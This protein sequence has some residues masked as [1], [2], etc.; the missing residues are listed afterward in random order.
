MFK[1]CDFEKETGSEKTKTRT[2]M[3]KCHR[4]PKGSK[5][6]ESFTDAA[7]RPLSEGTH[8]SS[9]LPPCTNCLGWLGAINRLI[10]L[11]DYCRPFRPGPCLATSRAC[12]GRGARAPCADCSNSHGLLSRHG[13]HIVQELS[14]SRG[15]RPGLTVL[16]SLLVS[17]DVKLYWTMLRHWSQL[18][19][20]MSERT[21]RFSHSPQVL[22]GHTG[23][24]NG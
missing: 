18:V 9:R 1:K 5:T 8:S 17:V 4:N 16:T 19:P 13:T 23:E 2:L 11:P 7:G 22:N 15:G 6:R 12:K 24:R 3:K 14:E 20:N 10:T 21:H